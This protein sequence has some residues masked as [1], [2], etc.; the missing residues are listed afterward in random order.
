[1]TTGLGPIYDGVGHVLVSP[2]DLLPVVALALL[3]GLNGRAAGR[4]ALLLLPLA[5]LAGGLVGYWARVPP[6]PG[7]TAAASLLLL[8]V[9]VAADRRL[10]AALV[11]G[12]AVLLGLLHGWLNGAAISAAGREPLGIVGIAGAVFLIVALVASQV[13]SAGA[14]WARIA[15]RVAG[16]WMAAIGLLMLGWSLSGRN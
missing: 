5:W 15:V 10:S 9:L 12:L 2:D 4:K 13:V 11:A 16:S 1:V 6:L 14:A 8:G 3:A 7:L